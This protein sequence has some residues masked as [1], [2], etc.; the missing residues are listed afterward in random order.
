GN[1]RRNQPL[2]LLENA[3]YRPTFNKEKNRWSTWCN[4]YMH[5]VTR[6]MWAS[7][8]HWVQR[9]GKWHELTAN[10]TFDWFRTEG[11]T[12]GWILIDAK[13]CGWIRQQN[14]T[15]GSVPRPDPAISN[16]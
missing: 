12:S 13:L 11:R 14:Q 16:L 4:I 8:P 3:R 2:S 1:H 6:A 7:V 9:K 15:R 10:A 5:D